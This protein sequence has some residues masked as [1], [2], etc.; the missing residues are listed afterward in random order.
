[1]AE[2]RRTVRAV[3]RI[4]VYDQTAPKDRV[5]L[6]VSGNVSAGGIFL[7]TQE[8]FEPGTIMK[9]Q[10]YLPND[11][12]EIV[13]VGEVVWT[14]GQRKASDQQPGMGVMF[15]KVDPADQERI[16]AFV[17]ERMEAGEIEEEY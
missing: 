13:T 16:R 6:Y 11:E 4:E 3:A 15:N 8:P 12:K 9:I 7:I 5:P 14:R 1:M 10:F 2:R 17:H